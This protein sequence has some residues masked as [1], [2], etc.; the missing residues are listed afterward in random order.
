M[1]IYG[2]QSFQDMKAYESFTYKCNIKLATSFS[3]E[4]MLNIV[5]MRTVRMVYHNNNKSS[6]S[7]TL[8]ECCAYVGLC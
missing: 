8:F 6:P 3:T 1:D 7:H 5:F 4:Q 2:E